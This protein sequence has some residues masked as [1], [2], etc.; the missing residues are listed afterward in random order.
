MVVLIATLVL[1]SIEIAVLF[2]V[3]LTNL[4]VCTRLIT[5]SMIAKGGG[6]RIRWIN[7]PL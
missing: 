6:G 3:E 1:E 4:C 2:V 5:S 7:K